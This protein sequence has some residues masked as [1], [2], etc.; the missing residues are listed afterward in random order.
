MI[1]TS[2]PGKLFL[3]GEYAVLEGHPALLAA[4]DRR[5]RVSAEPSEAWQIESAL[6][7]TTDSLSLDGPASRVAA[8]I[9]AAHDLGASTQ[10]HRV[11]VDSRLLFDGPRKLGFGSSA[12]VVVA[13]AGAILGR[14]DPQLFAACRRRHNEAQKT[15]GSGGDIAASL[16]GGITWLRAGPKLGTLPWQPP[17]AII[18]HP[19][20]ASTPRF[21]SQVKELKASSPQT[22]L[23]H[24][25][26]LGDI[27]E[28]AFAAVAAQNVTAFIACVRAAD[29]AL[30]AFGAAAHTPIITAFHRELRQYGAVKPAGAGGGDLSLLASDDLDGAI[31]AMRRDGIVCEALKTSSGL[32]IYCH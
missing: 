31:A 22:Y 14:S 12:A 15:E 10:P 25:A 11:R 26:T 7:A 16:M 13:V 21:V 5:V 1:E 18:T 3:F 9:L 6:F 19:T 28:S 4:V 23:S 30:E 17:I 24:L 32:T 2:A 27:T 29:A 20:S 8:G